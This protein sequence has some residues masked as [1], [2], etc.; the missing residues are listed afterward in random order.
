MVVAGER[1]P[2]AEA[3]K[4][5]QSIAPQGLKGLRILIAEDEPILSLLLEEMLS[6]LGCCVSG[7]AARVAQA[8]DLLASS[9]FDVALFDLKLHEESSEPAAD[10]CLARGIPVVFTTGYSPSGLAQRFSSFPVIEKPY[11]LDDLQRA[12]L[13]AVTP[14]G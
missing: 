10:V 11:T 7:A 2:D 5:P 6:E 9:T 12:L 8:L 14:R 13:S 1:L 4:R 3:A